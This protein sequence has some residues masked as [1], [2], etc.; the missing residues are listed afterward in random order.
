M[1]LPDNVQSG[2][3]TA[4]IIRASIDG[5]D[6]G[7]DPDGAGWE[8]LTFRF[9]PSV[10]VFRNT[11]ASPVPIILVSDIF[12]AT[13]NADGDLVG[14]DGTVGL[15][16]IATDD[17]DLIPTNWTWRVGIFGPGFPG[18][19]FSFLLPAGETVDLATVLRVPQNVGQAIADWAWAV[20]A[21]GNALEQAQ[22]AAGDAEE[23]ARRAEEA[24][25]QIASQA[26]TAT[27]DPDN[28]DLL[29]LTYPAYM[30]HEDGTSVVIPIGD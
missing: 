4:R 16:L 1:P 19:S 8:G 24:A 22:S 15:R 7:Q 26:M 20:Q 25:E 5:A 17:P 23:A 6:A 2:T 3:V 14:P 21:T 9:T 29:I 28:P 11:T 30:L 10:S 12:V 18:Q 13:S 27:V